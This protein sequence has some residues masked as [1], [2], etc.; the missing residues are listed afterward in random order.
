MVHIEEQGSDT[1]GNWSYDAYGSR[2]EDTPIG[3]YGFGG[4]RG[5]I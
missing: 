4:Q 1:L 3:P 5:W 2:S